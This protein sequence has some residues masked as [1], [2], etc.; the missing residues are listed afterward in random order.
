MR[1]I[2]IDIHLNGDV[3]IEGQGFSGSE[4]K[5]L[6]EPIERALGTVTN[7]Q[8]KPEYRETRVRPQTRTR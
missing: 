4:C 6:T 2:T 3:V 5:D 1:E 8:F 7:Q